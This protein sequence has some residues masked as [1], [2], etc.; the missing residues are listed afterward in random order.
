MLAGLPGRCAPHL[1]IIP[2]G[3]TW[4]V[5]RVMYQMRVVVCLLDTGGAT[6][7]CSLVTWIAREAGSEDRGLEA[8]SR[9]CAGPSPLVQPHGGPLRWQSQRRSTVIPPS[10]V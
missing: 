7:R 5:F 10:A 3:L 2:G 4:K 9:R 8:I 1:P 6:A